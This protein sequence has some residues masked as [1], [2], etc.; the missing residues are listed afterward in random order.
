M[1]LSSSDDTDWKY[2]LR[3]EYEFDCL[4]SIIAWYWYE[5]VQ[6]SL[7]LWNEYC[8]DGNKKKQTLLT[9]KSSNAMSS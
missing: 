8:Y 5:E 4:A 2:V 6:H 1:W 7:F 3:I 9:A